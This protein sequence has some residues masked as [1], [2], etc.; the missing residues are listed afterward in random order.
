MNIFTNNNNLQYVFFQKE[1]K[2]RQKRWLI[3][4]KDYDMSILYHLYKSN[5]VED[6]FGR[7][8]LV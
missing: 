2:L 6:S 5:V 1:F 3:L 4:L 7:I 8:T